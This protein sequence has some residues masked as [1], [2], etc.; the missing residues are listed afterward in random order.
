MERDPDQ[1]ASAR[2]SVP[3]GRSDGAGLA[4]TAV[5]VVTAEQA[6][7]CEAATI[8]AGTESFVLM[9]AAG[10]AAARLII[11][12]QAD[13]RTAGALIV[14][15]TGNNGGDAWVVA[16]ALARAGCPVT[17][18]SLGEPRSADAQRAQREA[19]GHL[20]AVSPAVQPAVVVDGVLGTGARGDA[21]GS[22]AEAITRINAMTGSAAIVALDVPSGMDATTGAGG[23]VVRA[24]E[25][26]TFGTLKRGLLLRR[27]ETGAIAVLDIGLRDDVHG[28][29]ADRDRTAAQRA[30][31]A[32]APA[33]RLVD[34]AW[35]RRAVPPIPADAHKG[36]RRRLAILGG[37][38]GMAGAPM[39]AARG[40]LRSGIG[41]V[42]LL[43]AP[44]NVPVVQAALPETMAARW[45]VTA[46]DQERAI[47]W[48]HVFLLGPGLGRT[49][50]S[51]A[52]VE[53]LLVAWR[54]P[55]VLDADA[56]NVFAGEPRSLGTLLGSRPAIVTPHPVEAARLLRLEPREV[57]ERR[58]EV[59]GELARALGATVVLKGP[60][61][62]I[63]APD[64]RVAVSASGAP[65]LGTAG[66]G[67]ALSGIIATLLGQ[68]LDAFGA[69][70][71]GAWIH[72]R[73]GEIA[74]RGGSVRGSS[75]EDVIAS[76]R[77]VWSLDEPAPRAPMLAELPS[78]GRQ[79]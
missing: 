56:L 7:A 66:S 75:L 51:R 37:A 76:L 15:G 35:V 5:R 53:R 79:R 60:P 10:E 54:G 44:T 30:A 12:R 9:R 61:T 26:Y 29:D 38:D 17:M 40:A 16:G 43:V 71:S 33:A 28:T 41:M 72:G 24:D 78:V 50:M 4:E 65:T 63:S 34:A 68:T 32:S 21:R 23:A 59:G 45:P 57:L 1:L 8:A 55:V 18:E 25:T 11:E 22:A 77:D 46:E 19:A 14:A 70:T 2:P 74:A 20:A 27:D 42:Q 13:V 64:G 3:F 58:F 39:L 47:D 62:I 49:V 6:M 31:P 52:L 36:V 48:A 69:A 67:D 73:A